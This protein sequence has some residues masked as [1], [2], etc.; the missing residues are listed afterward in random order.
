MNKIAHYFF[1]VILLFV[2]CSSTRTVLRSVEV[3]DLEILTDSIAD[4]GTAVSNFKRV[5]FDTDAGKD[6]VDIATLYREGEAV[7]SLQVRKINGVYKVKIIDN[8]K[9]D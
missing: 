5:V 7:G 8:L 2:A 1:I 3:S 6:S 4:S 9:I